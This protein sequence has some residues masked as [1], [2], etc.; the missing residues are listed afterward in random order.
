MLD[1]ESRR[2]IGEASRKRNAAAIALK[3]RWAETNW[4]P[5]CIIEGCNN[6]HEAK[7]Y[8]CMHYSRLKRWGDVGP[9]GRIVARKGEGCI[10]TAGYR[11]LTVNGIPKHE[12]ILVAER[13]MGGALPP[14]AVVHHV[15]E[16]RLN[17][18]EENLI[19][20]PDSAYHS[21]IH[22]RMRALAASGNASRLKCCYCK[23]Y[24]DPKN[25]YIRPNGKL[26]GYHRRCANEYNKKNRASL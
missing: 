23:E 12:H 6:K 4:G 22:Q 19:I 21:L 16:N 20:C 8:C 10:D 9:V 5:E 13:V 14:K 25:M 15:D 17:N 1:K 26:H 2:K 18:N 3:A 11:L 7:G 24:D